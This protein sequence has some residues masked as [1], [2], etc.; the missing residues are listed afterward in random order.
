MAAE[1]SKLLILGALL[2]FAASANAQDLADQANESY[3]AKEWQDA[4]NAYESLSQENKNTGQYLYRLG[5]SRRHLGEYQAAVNALEKARKAGVPGMFVDLE[6]AR[7]F[8]ARNEPELSAWCMSS[9]APFTT[10][11]SMP[12]IIRGVTYFHTP[13][14]SSHALILNV[15]LRK[16]PQNQKFIG[17]GSRSRFPK[18]IVLSP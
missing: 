1:L 12:R 3:L 16:G 5:V 13:R 8:S 15:D 6:L 7:L 9:S 4:A 10:S 2:A 18:T 14:I 11:C 17:H